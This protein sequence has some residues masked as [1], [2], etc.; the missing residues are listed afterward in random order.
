I[1]NLIFSFAQFVAPSFSVLTGLGQS[2]SEVSASTIPTY[3]VPAGYAFSIWFVIFTLAVV[4]A[5]RHGLPSSVPQTERP[6]SHA[7]ASASLYALSTLWMVI[8]Q[9]NPDSAWLVVIIIAMWLLALGLFFRQL[10]QPEPSTWV[11]RRVSRPLFGLYSGWL[12]LAVFLNF[13]ALVKEAA[14]AAYGV[15]PTGYALLIL[16]PGILTGL[17]ILV[18]SQGNTWYGS[19][20]LWALAGIMVT[21]SVVFVNPVVFSLALLASV[22]VGLILWNTHKTSPQRS[23]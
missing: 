21:N 16:T 6:A 15:S 22:A 20:L 11:E 13:S 17:Y 12:T 19:T 5:V 7:L 18:K 10:Q 14:L 9:L 4:D 23:A 3:E 1:L 2:I 8:A